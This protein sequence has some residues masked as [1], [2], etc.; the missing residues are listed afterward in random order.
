MK[1]NVLELKCP[2]CDG[3]FKSDKM[4]MHMSLH[5]GVLPETAIVLA[6]SENLEAI[7]TEKMHRVLRGYVNELA[8][9]GI[10][11]DVHIGSQIGV[12]YTLGDEPFKLID[13]IYRI[14]VE[15]WWPNWFGCC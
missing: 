9:H 2:I 8:S 13:F 7:L 3:A 11:V 14:E 12:C 1:K 5:D 10:G 6:T 4:Y 15:K